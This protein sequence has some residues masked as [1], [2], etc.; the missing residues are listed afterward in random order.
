[1]NS[2]ATVGLLQGTS[3][4]IHAIGAGQVVSMALSG[5][6]TERMH[7][8]YSTV[9][10]EEM[11]QRIAKVV[12]VAGQQV[13][14]AGKSGG[15]SGVLRATRLMSERHH[16]RQKHGEVIGRTVSSRDDAPVG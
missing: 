8:H 2:W 10:G 5:H 6:L 3:L 12:Q 14:L 1:M 11:R 16:R 9:S 15:E 7:E 13:P 4:A